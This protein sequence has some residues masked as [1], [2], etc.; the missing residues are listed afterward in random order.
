MSILDCPSFGAYHGFLDCGS[1]VKLLDSGSI[2]KLLD[3][4]SIVKLLDSGS[5]VKLL[6]SGSIVKL[7]DSGLLPIVK[8]LKQGFPVSKLKSSLYLCH[9]SPQYLVFR[10]SFRSI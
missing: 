6:D 1:I 4:G 9:K 10:V 5:I 7:L 3:S 8:L 2:V